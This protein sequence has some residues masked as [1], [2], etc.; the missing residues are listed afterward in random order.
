MRCQ[1]AC[2]ESGFTLVEL[3]AS[4]SIGIV[5]V[6]LLTQTLSTSQSGWVRANELDQAIGREQSVETVLRRVLT[7]IQPI[8]PGEHAPPL[9]RSATTFEFSAQPPQSRAMLGPL[10]GRLSVEPDADGRV[11][12]VLSTVAVNSQE[13]G[14]ETDRQVLL[15]G[16]QSAQMSYHPVQQGSPDGVHH[17]DST[18]ELI[19]VAWAYPG[20]NQHMKEVAVRP[21]LDVS[22]RCHLDLTSGTCRLP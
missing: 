7:H 17:D 16:L 2:G 1:C 5:L 22:G 14:M 18:P 6:M 10:R 4:I 13:G 8:L 3:L 12:L 19:V 9:I 15:T 20:S 11:A 21:R